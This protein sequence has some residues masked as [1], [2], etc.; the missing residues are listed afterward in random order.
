MTRVSPTLHSVQWLPD[1]SG[2]VAAG[3]RGLYVFDLRQPDQRMS[4]WQTKAGEGVLDV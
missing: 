3:D 4:H 2:I 1:T